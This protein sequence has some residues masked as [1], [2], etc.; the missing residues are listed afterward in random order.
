VISTRRAVS[1]TVVVVGCIVF[2]WLL[3]AQLLVPSLI[4]SAYRGHAVPILGRL[5]H[6]SKPLE[7]YQNFWNRIAWPVLP[8]LIVA[9][10]VAL[11][12]PG[13]RPLTL[14]LAV[15][16]VATEIQL[17]AVYNRAILDDENITLLQTAGN[18][19]PSWPRAPARAGVTKRF[20]RGS[21]PLSSIIENLRKR[22]VHPPVYS[23][24]LACWRRLFGFSLETARMFSVS[25]TLASI[26]GLYLL[27][28]AGRAER[29]HISLLVYSLSAVAPCFGSLARNYA[30][31]TLLIV[32]AALA[33]FLAAKRIEQGRVGAA[34]ALAAATACGM[35]FQT[36]YLSLFPAGVILIWLSARIWRRRRMLA[37]VSPFLAF[38]I[39]S[40]GWSVLHSQ[41]GARPDQAAGFEGWPAEIL[42]LL[43]SNADLLFSPVFVLTR[44]MGWGVVLLLC[45]LVLA[46]LYGLTR[47][48]RTAD[49]SFWILILGLSFAPSVGLALLD[50]KFDKSLSVASYYIGFAGP[51]LAVVASRVIAVGIDTSKRW[52]ALGLFG[53]VVLVQ[54][55]GTNWAYEQG[56][57]I[58]NV[59][60]YRTL[61]RM[62]R[63]SAS[64][65]QI[66]LVD[67][68]LGLT[69]GGAVLYE[70]DPEALVSSFELRNEG[71]EAW[72]TVRSFSDVWVW[73]SEQAPPEPQ[74]AFLRRFHDSG[75]YSVRERKLPWVYRFRRRAPGG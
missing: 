7:Y 60:H 10:V 30:L 24:L 1:P 20:F 58:G 43:Q 6:W 50:H 23:V 66:V 62:V 74:E 26:I 57:M 44:A 19:N 27:L 46:C 3:V 72:A 28:R 14:L 75:L 11:S 2:A 22:D 40:V 38:A 4:E 35:A 15:L 21:P 17:L 9:A 5:S 41:L 64:P 68:G 13:R 55:N 65:G 31:A 70:L 54:L 63:E 33:A 49:R 67:R 18:V 48:W 39:G 71:E 34:L 45:A 53:L 25:C 51:F 37:L 59:G 16:F 73:L 52:A 56:P 42:S 47:T 12:H 61:A 69:T 36:N 8:V 32:V 29:P